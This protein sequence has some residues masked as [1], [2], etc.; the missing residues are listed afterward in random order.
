M[1]K[2][3]RKKSTKSGILK[4]S[5]GEHQIGHYQKVSSHDRKIQ[6]MPP[7]KRRSKKGKIYFEARAN[8]SDLTRKKWNK[9]GLIDRLMGK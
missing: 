7:G 2:S 9:G 1:K 3:K 6:A 4:R 5:M 8:R